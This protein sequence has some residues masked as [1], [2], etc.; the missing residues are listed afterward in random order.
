MFFS[1]WP[2]KLSVEFDWGSEGPGWDPWP[3]RTSTSLTP[4]A[5]EARQITSAD[6]KSHMETN[7]RCCIWLCCAVRTVN[8]RSQ[9]AKAKIYTV[10]WQAPFCMSVFLPSNSRSRFTTLIRAMGLCV[11]TNASYS[12]AIQSAAFIPSMQWLI[13]AD[14]WVCSRPIIE[15][16][17]KRMRG[18][19]TF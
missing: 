16:E 10:V 7:L 8:L 6:P 18:K 2:G 19:V 14:C 1:S 17:T 5:L 4:A 3:V 11:T 12:K 13:S 15:E 9:V